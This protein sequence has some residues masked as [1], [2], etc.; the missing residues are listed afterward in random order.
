M[1]KLAYYRDTLRFD[2]SRH[3]PFTGTYR[4][5]CSQCE[6]CVVNGRPIHEHGCPHDVHE[7]DGCNEIIP[8]RQRYC[9]WC[10]S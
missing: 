9:D 4:I 3:V 2:L 10:A 8:A 1:S 6:S 7:C 5:R